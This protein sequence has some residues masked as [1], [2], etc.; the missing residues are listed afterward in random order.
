[1]PV[2]AAQALTR[3]GV[4]LHD[5]LRVV[6]EATPL[7]RDFLV[8]HATEIGVTELRHTATTP[9]QGRT[10]GFDRFAADA[11]TLGDRCDLILCRHQL[12]ILP[13]NDQTYA[14]P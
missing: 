1:M 14:Y 11:M 7:V 10:R 13:M 9:L 4:E 8:A 5:W 6:T 12:T 3:V 2:F